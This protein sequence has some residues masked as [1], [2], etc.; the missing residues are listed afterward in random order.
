[1]PVREEAV[2]QTEQ[3]EQPLMYQ[4]N[5]PENMVQVTG[6]LF[7]ILVCDQMTHNEQ[8]ALTVPCTIPRV[9]L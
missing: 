8:R 3:D 2:V 1:M 5:V 6:T 4:L 9:S 7:G